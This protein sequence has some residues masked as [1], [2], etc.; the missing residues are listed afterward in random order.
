VQ[1]ERERIIGFAGNRRQTD[2]SN[3][4]A[5]NYSQKDASREKHYY[6]IITISFAV[7]IR[8]VRE[9]YYQFYS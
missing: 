4:L 9:N 5:R 2:K 8:R 6:S 3:L 1:W 7:I